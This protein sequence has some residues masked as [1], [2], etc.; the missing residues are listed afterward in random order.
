MEN[1]KN[2]VKLIDSDMFTNIEIVS[3]IELL[4]TKIDI[5]TIS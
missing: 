4:C 1:L 2:V 5:N 3:L